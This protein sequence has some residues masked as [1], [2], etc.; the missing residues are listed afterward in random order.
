MIR[1]RWQ[2]KGPSRSL[3]DESPPFS[4]SPVMKSFSESPSI[5]SSSVAAWRTSAGR[6]ELTQGRMVL[7]GRVDYADKGGSST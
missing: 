5:A 7:K 3:R 6:Q 1:H 2:E 4:V